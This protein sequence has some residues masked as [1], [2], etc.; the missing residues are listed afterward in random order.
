M[1]GTQ[2]GGIC[3]DDHVWQT[4]TGKLV[5]DGFSYQRFTGTAR[6]DAGGRIE[7][8]CKQLP[9]HMGTEFKPNP[10]EHLSSVL[11][12]MGHLEDAREV[13]IAKH[14]K[15]RAAGRFVG[16][17][18]VW[19]LVYGALVG[20]GYRPWRLVGI[21]SLVWATCTIVYLPAVNPQWF[22][23]KHHL[24][25]PAVS[26]AEAICRSTTPPEKHLNSCAAHRPRYR[27][28]FVPA[29]SAEVLIPLITFG[30]KGD[31]R[32]VVSTADGKPLFF[33]WVV[34]VI[35][36]FEIIFGWLASLLLVA[37]VGNLIKRE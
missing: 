13:A 16:G 22:D 11:R 25:R 17:S 18:K 14:K 5:L 34:R 23:S 28:F 9:H 12:N 1:S 29:Y 31:W 3:D 7:W 35:Y 26:Q 30:Y 24:I 21:M 19:D 15:M 2:V 6:T 37:A 33:G 32:P 10:W 36:W 20:Y 4:S 8:L 27:D